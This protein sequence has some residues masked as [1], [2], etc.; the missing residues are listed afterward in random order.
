MPPLP[1]EADDLFR[2]DAPPEDVPPPPPTDPTTA[3][4]PVELDAAV[5][6]LAQ[7][8]PSPLAGPVL[9]LGAAG[10]YDIL[11]PLGT[12]G[13]ADVVHARRRGPGGFARDVALKSVSSAYSSQ[14]PKRRMFC[15]E[16]RLAAQLSH[17]N[18]AQ[19]YD[20]LQHGD[21]YILVLE[22]VD[23]T[24]LRQALEVAHHKG[25][26]FSEGFAAYLC[27]QVADALACAHS[28]CDHAGK[29]L[30]IVHRD[31]TP[32]NVMVTRAGN[33]KLL[34]FGIALS[35]L[36][37]RDATRAS[38]VKGKY[39]Y[40]SPEQADGRAIDARSDLFSLGLILVELLTLR[41]VFESHSQSKTILQV[42]AA[43]PKQVQA[44]VDTMPADL[45]QLACE[46]LSKDPAQRPATGTELA[47]RLRAYLASRGIAY[48]AADAASE[49]A[50]LSSLP[51]VPEHAR[52]AT[53][54][55]RA[56][57]RVTRIPTP[58]ASP[59]LPTPPA[60]SPDDR[61]IAEVRERL[62]N[63]QT[64]RRRLLLPAVVL[65]AIIVAGNL[66]VFLIIRANRPARENAAELVKTPS[67]KRAAEQAAQKAAT[68]DAPATLSP[69]L[70][71]PE[72]RPPPSPEPAAHPTVARTMS[73]R[74]A[75]LRTRAPAPTPTP[76]VHYRS[77]DSPTLAAEAPAPG[78]V[79]LPRGSMIPARLTLPADP[80]NP[81]PVTAEVTA[82]VRSPN[83][84]LAVPRGSALTCASQPGQAARVRVTCDT[85]T[86]GGRAIAVDLIAFG[87]DQRPGLPVDSTD[88]APANTG[89]SAANTAID[90]AA[91]VA[92][93]L[94]GG[95]VAGELVGGAI[96]GTRDLTRRPTQMQATVSPAPKGSPFFAYANAAF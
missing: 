61:R 67:Q 54:I 45:V 28:A 34:D 38:V 12:G 23:G 16:A 27:A 57:A 76:A 85:L 30:G 58:A 47:Q 69:T 21:D 53:S 5:E 90:T 44:A 32:H 72:L 52:D 10:K 51:D 22:Y 39:S 7:P 78:T 18:I 43:D 48:S 75:G 96:Q 46:L 66:L 89:A 59:V 13:M 25:T 77:L 82:D 15:D 37:G 42:V 94:V 11:R 64:P 4:A 19:V 1:P 95:D 29:H 33:V 65:G 26:A 20:L 83:G 92:T 86:I 79:N 36:E 63:P 17:P 74:S 40:M 60:A 88:P 71:A 24:S 50:A 62:R 68:V 9:D 56:R 35:S 6:A 31:V 84:T 49:L 93:R 70:L 81:G 2:D 3:E 91:A 87:A 55:G 8:R 73:S 80:A 41:R 14:D